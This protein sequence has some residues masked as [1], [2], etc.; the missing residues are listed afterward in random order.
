MAAQLSV[1]SDSRRHLSREGGRRS[2]L[3]N[4][5]KG[6]AYKT[7][8]NSTYK[9][10]SCCF[11]FN[12]SGSVCVFMYEVVVAAEKVRQVDLALALSGFGRFQIVHILILCCIAQIGAYSAFTAGLIA[13]PKIASS[14]VVWP[15]WI[16]K[17]FFAWIAGIFIDK[18]GRTFSLY[19][20]LLLASVTLIAACYT[21]ENSIEF[22]LVLRTLGC[23]FIGA[24]QVINYVIVAELCPKKQRSRC[25][26][27]LVV[28]DCIGTLYGC[29]MLAVPF[30]IDGSLIGLSGPSWRVRML[31]ALIPLPVA[32]LF[33][34]IFL[35][36]IESPFFLVVSGKSPRAFALLER[37][38]KQNGKHDTFK[39]HVNQSEF[40][41]NL[42]ASRAAISVQERGTLSQVSRVPKMGALMALWAIQAIT[43]W[44][45]MSAIPRLYQVWS[46][47][48][49]SSSTTTY[50]VEILLLLYVF[51]F[52]G[53]GI[54]AFSSFKWG[55]HKTLF[56]F[57]MVGAFLLAITT[58]SLGLN[59]GWFLAASV[60]G[61]FAFLTPIWG[62]LFVITTE[63]F[64]TQC[65]AT[66]LGLMLSTRVV[67]GVL[68]LAL[69]KSIEMSTHLS[70]LPT[71]YATV[72]TIF[73]IGGI[74]IAKRLVPRQNITNL[75][76][77][78]RTWSNSVVITSPKRIE[79][80]HV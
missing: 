32:L 62:I 18:F 25:L 55:A 21:G 80:G 4:T 49:S 50:N 76:T 5:K 56:Y 45:A 64:P 7:S 34:L 69:P 75:P 61:L 74:F 24:I 54:A 15:E 14:V 2:F 37:I 36:G 57:I 16:M 38:A 28:M 11:F 12:L 31:L 51:E 67:Q 52:V 59:L 1:P 60:C 19:S 3:P 33:A 53:I 73:C 40:I 66:A 48:T 79:N 20:A 27:F 8:T 78:I 63:V 6:L 30:P 39:Q 22:Y 77:R 29:A 70:Y 65:R 35:R 72:S 26:F 68:E 9:I 58:I 44:G 43:Y 23:F 47:G 71:I 10:F 41:R 46:N 17:S 13:G 42:S